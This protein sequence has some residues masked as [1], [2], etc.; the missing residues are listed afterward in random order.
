MITTDILTIART[1]GEILAG[2]NWQV[3]TAESCTGGLVASVLTETPGSSAWFEQGIVSYSNIVKHR[4]LGVQDA[5]LQQYG[6][7]SEEVAREM[8]MGAQKSAKAEIGLAV[9][10]I[11]GPDG[12][13]AEKPVGTVCFGWAM[14]DKIVSDTCHFD[15]ERQAVRLQSVHFILQRLL[16]YLDAKN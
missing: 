16:Q 4:L 10:G 12:G 9:T 11:A 13:S 5:T 8:A 2:R 6:A 14:P 1:I 3:T 7:V 15:G